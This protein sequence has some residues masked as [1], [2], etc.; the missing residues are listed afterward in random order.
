MIRPI[1]TATL[2][3]LFLSVSALA[4]NAADEF[5]DP[6]EMAEARTELQ[7][8]HCAQTS[9]LVLGERL[10]YHS[11]NGDPLLVWEGQGWIGTLLV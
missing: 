1:A 7:S 5:Y 8:S 4:Q 11:N 2:V 10:E 9:W 3:V 6:D